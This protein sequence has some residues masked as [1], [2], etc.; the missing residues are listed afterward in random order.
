MAGSTD[1]TSDADSA[2]SVDR[3]LYGLIVLSTVFGIGHHID[4]IIRGNH[5]G[6]PLIPEVKFVYSVRLWWN[7][8]DGDF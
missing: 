1:T 3:R 2:S 6:W 8:R 5:V 7:A 4:H